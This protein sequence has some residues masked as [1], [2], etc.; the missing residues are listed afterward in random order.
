MSEE[1]NYDHQESEFNAVIASLRRMDEIKKYLA[2]STINK[3][4]KAQFYYLKAFWKE[5]HPIL[6]PTAKD[7]KPTEREEQI[8]N[9][10]ELRTL[11]EQ[12]TDGLN[13]NM[14]IDKLD[15]WEL[16]LRELEQS[17]KLNF[18][19]GRDIRWA[20]SRK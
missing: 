1:R 12:N 5:I 13:N 20:M 17:H 8:K 10:L 19:T 2:L 4:F 9:Y 6:N 11:I 15:E 7:G 3:D 14:I 16:T 18:P